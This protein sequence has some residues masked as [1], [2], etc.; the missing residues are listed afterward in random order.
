MRTIYIIL[1]LVLIVLLAVFSFDYWQ[2][3][4]PLYLEFYDIASHLATM[5]GFDRC[6]GSTLTNF[7]EY[8]PTTSPNYYLPFFHIVGLLFLRLGIDISIIGN[9]FIF[10]LYP[11]SLFSLWFFMRKIFG[12]RTAFYSVMLLSLPTLWM[13]KIW[14]NST[15][16]LLMILIPLIFCALLSRRYIVATLLILCSLGTHLAAGMVPAV[17]LIYALHNREERKAIFIILGLLAILGLPLFWIA[18][19][20]V[21]FFRIFG[22]G[23]LSFGSLK[24]VLARFI[25]FFEFGQKPYVYLGILAALGILF[26]YRKRGRYLLLPSYFLVVTLLPLRG[27]FFRYTEIN[28]V[29]PFCMLGGVF[30]GEIH[31]ILERGRFALIKGVSISVSIILIAHILFFGLSLRPKYSKTPTIIFLNRPEIWLPYKLLF[32]MEGRLRIVQ[33][34]KDKTDEGDFIY[35][36]ASPNLSRM[37]GA[38]TRRS[39]TSQTQ[40]GAKMAIAQAQ[41]PGFDFLEKSNERFSIYIQND[42]S[43]VKK[44]NIPPPL[45]PIS[46]IYWAFMVMVFLM[47]VD[48]FY[49]LFPRSK[50]KA[51]L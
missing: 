42:Q 2:G 12:G 32:P 10:A 31:K 48:L 37:V 1:A 46:S 33:L 23:F 24:D 36:G 35:N 9:Y 47:G 26:C 6:G 34:I 44:V 20:R 41:P 39:V 13:E 28:C 27:A 45:V 25:S 5:V 43:K 40:D 14:G 8:T 11:L 21:I 4:Y 17:L 18:W 49:P 29:L 51:R 7:W 50:P 22:E 38:F 3:Y 15:F 30:L 16:G 19:K